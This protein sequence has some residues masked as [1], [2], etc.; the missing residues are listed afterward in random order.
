M[1]LRKARRARGF[2]QQ[3]IGDSI[4]VKQR[5]YAAWEEGRGNPSA[6]TLVLLAD[7][8]GITNLRAFIC[9]PDFDIRHQEKE[10]IRI[11]ASPMQSN[12]AKVG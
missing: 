4:C 12:F 10:Y 1:N 7:I 8:L 11:P 5:T 3:E 2:K 6:E 9:D